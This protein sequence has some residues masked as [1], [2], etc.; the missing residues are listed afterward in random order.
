MQPTA[1]FAGAGRTGYVWWSLSL[2]GSPVFPIGIRVELTAEET[3]EQNFL[4]GYGAAG[5][6]RDF[7]GRRV[8]A[9]M[10]PD[11]AAGPGC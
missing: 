8:K 11:S 1:R 3:A 9:V 5:W 6:V 2:L 4:K 7:R 10:P